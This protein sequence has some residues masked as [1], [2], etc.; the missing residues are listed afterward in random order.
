M[1]LVLLFISVLVLECVISFKL[2][3]L[4]ATNTLFAWVQ[5]T[6][7]CEVIIPKR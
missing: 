7:F 3:Q 2:L 1:L 4:D 5:G 6:N